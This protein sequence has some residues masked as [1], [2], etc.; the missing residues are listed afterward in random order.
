MIASA[1]PTVS[2]SVINEPLLED[3]PH[4][5]SCTQVRAETKAE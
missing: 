4:C 2:K 5:G 3:R 1:V